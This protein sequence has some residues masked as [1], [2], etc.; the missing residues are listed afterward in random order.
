MKWT[1]LDDPFREV[2]RGEFG[3]GHPPVRCLFG[4]WVVAGLWD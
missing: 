1:L 3:E 2:V 4:E